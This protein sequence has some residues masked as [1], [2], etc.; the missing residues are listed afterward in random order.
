MTAETTKQN[1]ADY[2]RMRQPYK[3]ESPAPVP[4]PAPQ[5]AE[6]AAKKAKE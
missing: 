2:G 3:G 4:A 5:P 1:P 6:P